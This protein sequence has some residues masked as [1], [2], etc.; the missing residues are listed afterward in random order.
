[1]EQ[2][3]PPNGVCNLGSLDLSK[4]VNKNKEVDWELLEIATKLGV[5]FLDAVVNAGAFPT[6]EIE[7]WAKDNRSIGLGVMGFADLCLMKKIAYGSQES[8]DVLSEILQFI[9][10]VAEEESIENGKSLGVPKYGKMIPTPRR[11]VTLL[12][13]APTGSVS[14]IAGCSSGIE[15]VFSEI[16]VRNDKTGSYTFEND[17]AEEDYFR[18][19]VS[20]NG[21]KEVTWDEH[22]AILSTAQKYVDSGI[23]KTINFPNHTHRETIAKALMMAWKG[24]CKGV[25]VY[26]NGSRKTE[27]LTPK[28]LK[29]DKCPQCGNDIEEVNGKKKC[30][31]C[32]KENTIE[33][34]GAIYD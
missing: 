13:I 10:K 30:S 8:L 17:L 26:R 16:T 7:Q 12:T 19:A 1:M 32:N 34:V 33:K 2:P 22:I 20:S 31:Y 14:L 29:K 5:D 21:A 15:P 18:C 25:A 23:S 11:N 24:G 3:L 9:S 4:F 27:V 28:N 6:P